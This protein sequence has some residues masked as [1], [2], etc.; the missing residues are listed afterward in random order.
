MDN[1][2]SWNPYLKLIIDLILS[3]PIFSNQ[4]EHSFAVSNYIKDKKTNLKT[5]NLKHILRV[6]EN[7]P[8]KFIDFEPLSYARICIEGHRLSDEPSIEGTK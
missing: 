2:L 3:L 6:L 1:D 7:G 5:K 4:C 8:K